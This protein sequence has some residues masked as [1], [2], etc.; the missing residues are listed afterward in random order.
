MM[1]VFQD[2]HSVSKSSPIIPFG[3][4]IAEL[5]GVWS[6]LILEL[7]ALVRLALMLLQVMSCYQFIY[8]F[9]QLD[10]RLTRT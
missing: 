4:I 9:C 7:A 1:R 3:G 10:Q 2:A 5:V 8:S 6:V